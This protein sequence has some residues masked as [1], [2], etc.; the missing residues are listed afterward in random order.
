MTSGRWYKIMLRDSWETMKASYRTADLSDEE[1]MLEPALRANHERLRIATDMLWGRTGN[2][3]RVD[4]RRCL[5]AGKPAH[6]P[7]EYYPTRK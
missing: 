2:G 1:R 7:D 4:F 3:F 5:S 6:T